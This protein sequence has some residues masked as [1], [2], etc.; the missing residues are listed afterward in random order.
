MT[1]FSVMRLNEMLSSKPYAS[2][3]FFSVPLLALL[4]ATPILLGVGGGRPGG[5]FGS[6]VDGQTPVITEPCC[7]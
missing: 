1:R 5:I 6:G 4:F 2:F 3:I 7:G